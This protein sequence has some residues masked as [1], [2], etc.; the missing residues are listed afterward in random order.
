MDILFNCVDIRLLFFF[1]IGIIKAQIAG[2]GKRLGNAKIQ[3]DRFCVSDV[4]VAVWFRRETRMNM[5]MY[6]LIQI[7]LERRKKYNVKTLQCM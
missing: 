3:A 2:A 7:I 6:F 4:Q 5:L 1:W